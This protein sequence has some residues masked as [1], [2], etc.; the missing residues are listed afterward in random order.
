M[1]HL[2]HAAIF[3]TAFALAG[4]RFD[5]SPAEFDVSADVGQAITE[6]LEVRN[7]GDEPVEFSLVPEGA[8]V[9][10]SE[11]SGI[12]RPD[13]TAHIGISA[14]CEAP[15]ERHTDIAV[16]G[17]TGNK[18]IVVHVPFVLRCQAEQ[19]ETGTHLV[20]LELFQ[21]PPIYKK[22]Y[23]AGTETEPVTL[24]P[25]HGAVPAIAAGIGNV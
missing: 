17:R 5:V 22:D 21:G 4:C 25:T 2:R 16:T 15:G 24:A 9:T 8:R 7:T 20:S 10:L 18:S 12:L 11:T 3:L 1:K 13:A 6:S 23:R 14:E 19:A